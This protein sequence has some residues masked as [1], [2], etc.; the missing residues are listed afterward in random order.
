MLIS[1]FKNINVQ[2]EHFNVLHQIME[3]M[4]ET[5]VVTQHVEAQVDFLGQQ[6]VP[7]V[8]LKLGLEEEVVEQ[9]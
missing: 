6:V 9:M 3:V 1:L 2:K 5:Q 8:E 4:V 7:V